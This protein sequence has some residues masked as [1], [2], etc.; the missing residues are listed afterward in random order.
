MADWPQ[1]R[2]PNRNGIS[3]ETGILSAFPSGGPKSVWTA[4]IGTGF[5]TV[6][7]SRG[8]VYTMGN[9][10]EQDWVSCLNATTGKV[11]WVHKYPQG[12]GDY[13]GPRATPTV[14]EGKVYTFSREGLAFCLDAATGKILWQKNIASETRAAAPRWGFAG[15]PLIFDNLLIFNVGGGGVALDKNTGRVVWSS[16]TDIPGYASPVAF[17]LGGKRGVAIFAKDSLKALDPASGRVQWS[18][19]WQTSYDVNAADP[20][21][22]GDSVFISSNYG[23]G[24][25]VLRIAGGKPTSVWENRNMKNHF[26]SCVLVGGTLY[27]NDENTLRALNYATGAER[28]NMRGMDKGGLIAADGKLIALTGRG[29]LVII[30]AVPTAFTELGRAKILDGQTWAHPV[31]ANGLLY[32]RNDK[33]NLVCLDMR[34]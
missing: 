31:L 19:P 14:A 1:W 20:I 29:E 23:K 24:G 27:G 9:Y 15:S 8:R 26:N 7:V 6:A 4:N 18:Y 5:T 2:G 30:R 10:Q 21:F 13:S 25:S 33:G 3:A 11:I 34:R 28:W 17:T 32:C 16:G 22:S 12:A